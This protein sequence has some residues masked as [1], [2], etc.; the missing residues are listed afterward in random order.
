MPLTK[1]EKFERMEDLWGEAYGYAAGTVN[2]EIC[3][4]LMKQLD[5]GTLTKEE[6]EEF[7]AHKE[8]VDFNSKLDFYM[9]EKVRHEIDYWE[10]KRQ[11]V[12][13]K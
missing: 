12:S 10:S 13:E 6:L 2:D 9:I 4:P 3:Y 1:D 8:E 5:K 11:P 7:L